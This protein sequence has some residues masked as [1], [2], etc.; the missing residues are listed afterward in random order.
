MAENSMT[1]KEISYNVGFSSPANFNR[2]FK[3][4]MGVTPSEMKRKQGKLTTLN[5][6]SVS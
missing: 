1:I 4:V 2:A 6:N 5:S 3:Q